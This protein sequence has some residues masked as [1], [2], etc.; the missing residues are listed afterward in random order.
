M[1]LNYQILL[2][3][4]FLLLL[5][6]GCQD[7]KKQQELDQREQEISRRENDFAS[8]EADYKS[9]MAMR[10]SLLASAEPKADTLVVESWPADIAGFWNSKSVCRESNCPDYVIGD[11]RF[12]NWEFVSDSTGLYTRVTNNNNQLLRIYSAKFDSTGIALDFA[13]DSSAAKTVALNVALS[14]INKSL[15]KGQQSMM[16]DKG[17][18]AKFSIELT[19]SANQ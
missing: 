19:R 10:D 18:T 16:L 17:C 13:T 14:R 4:A 11:Q 9:L 6:P 3:P 15:M 2:I 7:N 12:N 8:K 5:L 1:K